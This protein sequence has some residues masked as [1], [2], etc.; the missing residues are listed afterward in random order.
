VLP[1]TLVALYLSALNDGVSHVGAKMQKI[2]D[3]TAH[4]LKLSYA[5][6]YQQRVQAGGAKNSK[7]K[8]LSAMS[9]DWSERRVMLLAAKEEAPADDES[10][11]EAPADDE[12]SEE[13]PAKQKKLPVPDVPADLTTTDEHIGDR[14]RFCSSHKEALDIEYKL[15]YA[16]ELHKFCASNVNELSSSAVTIFHSNFAK[17]WKALRILIANDLSN[18][19]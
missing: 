16:Q 14:Y 17:R 3:C 19:T 2:D 15:C 6:L 18:G 13:A 9:G 8:C 1:A 12:S 7:N 10:S 4:N 11:E 5:M